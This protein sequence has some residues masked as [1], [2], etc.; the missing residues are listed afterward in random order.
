[1]SLG[2]KILI[3]YL[4]NAIAAINPSYVPAGRDVPDAGL[5]AALQ[6]GKWKRLSQHG[7]AADHI[8]GLIGSFV[9]DSYHH[10]PE[11]GMT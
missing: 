5:H 9:A 7:T 3:K 1:M 6:H 2:N 10:L 4:P 11:R 8:P